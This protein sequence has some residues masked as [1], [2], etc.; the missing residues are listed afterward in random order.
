MRTLS[1]RQA[2]NAILLLQATPAISRKHETKWQRLPREIDG[3]TQNDRAT[4]GDTNGQAEPCHGSRTIGSWESSAFRNW[5]VSARDRPWRRSW[6]SSASIS[7]RIRHTGR[8]AIGAT[9]PVGRSRRTWPGVD[10][11]TRPAKWPTPSDTVAAAASPAPWREWNRATNT[12]GKPRPSWSG[13]CTNHYSSSDPIPPHSANSANCTLPRGELGGF[14]DKRA[15][16]REKG[17]APLTP[18]VTQIH[19]KHRISLGGINLT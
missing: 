13:S 7:G 18:N 10:S 3:A 16:G 9:T 6:A 5:N 11:D 17:G 4:R 2:T 12:Y 1:P 19:G 8:P 15:V 14:W